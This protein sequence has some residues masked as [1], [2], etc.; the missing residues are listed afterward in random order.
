MKIFGYTVLRYNVAQVLNIDSKNFDHNTSELCVY[1]LCLYLQFSTVIHI[2]KC[3][4][5]TISFLVIFICRH[6]H[7]AVWT[8]QK[9]RELLL[10]SSQESPSYQPHPPTR[11]LLSTRRKLST[12]FSSSIQF[13]SF[14]TP[15]AEGE[16]P[17]LSSNQGDEHSRSPSRDLSPE[18][19]V[20][21]E[22]VMG[23]GSDPLQH[24][25][26]SDNVFME[27]DHHAASGSLTFQHQYPSNRNGI[28]TDNYSN[29]A[30]NM[31]PQ[32]SKLRPHSHRPNPLISHTNGS[33]A[34]SQSAVFAGREDNPFSLAANGSPLSRRATLALIGRSHPG[35]SGH[36]FFGPGSVSPLTSGHKSRT[37]SGKI[38]K[39]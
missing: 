3:M 29:M 26:A 37:A 17:G 21:S 31:S 4:Y 16:A 34:R 13:S 15:I 33:R 25:S 9:Y 19:S 11:P 2:S 39:V 7:K 35:G 12:S 32:V 36:S 28:Q 5:N 10:S 38:I 20:E 14:P 27:F 22:G 24:S 23:E 1:G 6:F 18:G 30:A 8:E